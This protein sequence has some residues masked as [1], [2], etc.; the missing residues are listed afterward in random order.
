MVSALT[1]IAGYAS[2]TNDA[3]SPI[4]ISERIWTVQG[5]PISSF[6]YVGIIEVRGT[7]CVFFTSKHSGGPR[8]VPFDA[9]SPEDIE[10]IKK[11]NP[12]LKPD[13]IIK[14]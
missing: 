14:K 8:T 10:A 3:P 11:I 5:R 13:A 7:N 1:P 4:S 9:L 12:E 6:R 2:D